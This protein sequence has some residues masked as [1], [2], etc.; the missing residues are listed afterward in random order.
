MGSQCLLSLK[1]IHWIEMSTAVRNEAATVAADVTS[2]EPRPRLSKK[3]LSV[4]DEVLLV[5][6]ALFL[7]RLARTVVSISF[8]LWFLA[9]KTCFGFALESVY[10]VLI[11]RKKRRGER[12]NDKM[13]SKSNKGSK[14]RFKLKRTSSEEEDEVDAAAAAANGDNGVYTSR[15]IKLRY[16]GSLKKRKEQVGKYIMSL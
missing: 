13:G 4:S 9:V 3:K 12:D 8:G 5:N 10:I 2:A 15:T 6:I 11:G 7:T 14:R 16:R 1:V